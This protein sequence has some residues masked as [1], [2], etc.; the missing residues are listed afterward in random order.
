MRRAQLT[1]VAR[2]AASAPWI[3]AGALLLAASTP[4]LAQEA[5]PPPETGIEV[6]APAAD[7]AAAG[8]VA[9]TGEVAADAAP[10]DEGGR[11]RDRQGQGGGQEVAAVPATGAG[12]GPI[13]AALD[14]LAVGTAIGAAVAGAAA[15]RRRIVR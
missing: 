3:V 10:A 13:G 4:A 2:S 5:T 12:P 9:A 15:L 14:P 6:V 11:N 7:E 8:E 1:R